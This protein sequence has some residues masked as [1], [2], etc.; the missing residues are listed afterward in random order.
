MMELCL[1]F[2]GA[3]I[4]ANCK[5]VSDVYLQDEN[6]RDIQILSLRHLSACEIM[7]DEGLDPVPGF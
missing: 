6:H 1:P 5:I 7:F 3:V 4:L 2:T